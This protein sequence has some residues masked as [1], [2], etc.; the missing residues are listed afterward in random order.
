MK[1]HIQYQKMFWGVSEN[2]ESEL[3]E[4][5]DSEHNAKANERLMYL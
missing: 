2:N 3:S 5:S 1:Q 4:L